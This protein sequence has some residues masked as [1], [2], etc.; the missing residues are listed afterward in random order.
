M[1]KNPGGK[2]WDGAR[3][4]NMQ[5]PKPQ[6]CQLLISSQ[7]TSAAMALNMADKPNQGQGA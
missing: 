5:L 6:K 4:A 7:Q 3:D 1:R 2:R